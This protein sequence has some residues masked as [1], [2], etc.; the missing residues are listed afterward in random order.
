MR[1]IMEYHSTH[2][3]SPVGR[4]ML[5]ANDKGLVGLWIEG[6]K[7]FGDTVAGDFV[8][9]SDLPIFTAARKWL[10]AYFAGKVPPISDLTLAPIGG[11]FRQCVWKILCEIPSGQTLTYGQI[12][13]KVATRMNKKNMSSRAVGGAV[14]H[15]PVSIIIPCHRVIGS[16]GNLTGY[17]GG[18]STKIKLLEHEGVDISRFFVP[19]KGTAL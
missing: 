13:K 2:Y 17:A 14:G 8:E 10:D 11:E 12:A 16:G 4:I 15:N 6:Q 19:K 5:G 1:R 18:I 7:Y 9:T 3:D